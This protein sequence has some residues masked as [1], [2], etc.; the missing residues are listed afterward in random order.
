MY[1]GS[2]LNMNGSSTEG[3]LALTLL[4]IIT[5]LLAARAVSWL[6]R[7]LGQPAVVG[8]MA[9]GILL[10]PSLFGALAP[11]TFH[12]LF[13]SGVQ[14][15][16][17]ISQIGLILL[18]FQIGMEF[19]FSHL[20]TGTNRRAV[21]F[22][23]PAGILIP[24]LLGSGLGWFGHDSLDAASP[25]TIFVLFMA[26]SMCITAMPV[27]GRLILE[28][29]LARTRIGA[30]TIT[31]AAFDDVTGWLLLAV[32]SALATS[33]LDLAGFALRLAAIGAYLLVFWF[34]VRPVISG[35]LKP[36]TKKE[37]PLSPGA[38]TCVLALVFLSALATQ[39]L[40]IHAIFGGF[41]MGVLLHKEFAF[42]QAWRQQVARFVT[43]FFLPIFFTFT[44]LR[45]NI[46]GLGSWALWGWCALVF[47]CAFA[48]KFGGCWAAARLAG[49]PQRHSCCIG[50]MMNTRGLLELIVANVGY[51]LGLIPAS[52]F[53]MLV[54]MA[55]L[56]T[57]I[58][59]PLLKLWRADSCD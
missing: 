42:V 8:E 14:G 58:T 37:D 59:A 24:F 45:T 33:H 26:V 6:F 9:A 53:T 48:G 41:W 35:W 32:I 29:N 15:L 7:R 4:Q 44:G 19:D 46:P 40:G 31:C 54:L 28:L 25:K 50:I 39:Q 20:K 18:M 12:S 10:G 52:V 13:G 16:S 27:L 57:A 51:D 47:V 30:L 17:I 43:V 55:L 11:G 36:K 22:I 5:I 3:V 1:F 2:L 23:W 34:L 49:L 56:S 38:M 21:S